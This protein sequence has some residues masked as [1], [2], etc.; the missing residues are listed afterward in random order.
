MS[1]T[2]C[3]EKPVLFLEG[4]EVVGETDDGGVYLDTDHEESGCP[5]VFLR[6]PYAVAPELL[7]A[8]LPFLNE[9]ALTGL[10]DDFAWLCLTRTEYDALKSAL[11]EA[12]GKTP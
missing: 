8:A 6:G 12:E 3:E 7:K 4:Y 2:K 11:A 10:D 1:E 9:E 5:A